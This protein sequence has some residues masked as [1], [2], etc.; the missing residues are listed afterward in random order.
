MGSSVG[1]SESSDGRTAAPADVDW[2]FPYGVAVGV[3]SR[4]ATS[5]ARHFPCVPASC[6]GVRLVCRFSFSD[7]RG[8]GSSVIG[9]PEFRVGAV[10]ASGAESSGVVHPLA[11]FAGR[12]PGLVGSREMVCRRFIPPSAACP[13]PFASDTVGVGRS[14]TTFGNASLKPFPRASRA[15]GVGRPG[16]EDDTSTLVGSTNGGRSEHT[17]LRIEPEAGQV[18]ENGTECPQKRFIADVSHT[19]RAGFHVTVGRRGEKAGDIFDHHQSG[20]E[21][22]DGAGDMP[23]QAGAGAL[24][25]ARAAPGEADV[26][27]G[28]PGREDVNGLHVPEVD[29]GEVAVVGDV[30]PVVGE[31]L[32]G[33]L[34][35]VLAAVLVRRLVLGV[36]GDRAAEHLLY[37]HV[38]SAVAGAQGADAGCHRGTASPSGH[39]RITHPGIVSTSTASVPAYHFPS[40]L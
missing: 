8:V 5:A 29:G 17:P 27:A 40:W 9:A 12:T 15:R 18:C 30:G 26:L 4:C 35:G 22:G 33:V 25:E 21:F 37:G 38:E 11:A 19:P 28:E 23:P 3:G 16:E 1:A 7:A 6:D 20:S 31:D 13:I 36:P 24:G 32:G 14:C 10:V 2:L 34:V 39:T